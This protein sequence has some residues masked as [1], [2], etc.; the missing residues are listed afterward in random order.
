MRQSDM[1]TDKSP[2]KFP[3]RFPPERIKALRERFCILPGSIELAGLTLLSRKRF[4]QVPIPESDHGK[5]GGVRLADDWMFHRGDLAAGREHL[6]VP[7]NAMKFYI[8]SMSRV[9]S[10][11]ESGEW[12]RT[13]KTSLG[14][15]AI[16]CGIV[17]NCSTDMEVIALRRTFWEII[18]F[19][20]ETF[21]YSPRLGGLF[22]MMKERPKDPHEL[23]AIFSDECIGHAIAYQH[24]VQTPVAVPRALLADE[25]AGFEE[26]SAAILIYSS[27]MIEGND[28]SIIGTLFEWAEKFLPFDDVFPVGVLKKALDNLCTLGI[29]RDWHV[30]QMKDIF[31]WP[32]WAHKPG[33]AVDAELS[34]PHFEGLEPEFFNFVLTVHAAV[35]LE[36]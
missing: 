9:F 18:G 20:R 6:E 19:F 21:V 1:T 29:L 15:I 17:P 26:I 10:V 4:R 24:F 28:I 31:A 16:E 35:T 11:L 34:D 13:G 23:P 36:S 32:E 27:M 22:P 12:D 33:D 5:E 14:D 8:Y 2:D 30:I 25:S 7:L 3:D